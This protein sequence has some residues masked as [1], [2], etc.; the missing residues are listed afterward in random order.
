MAFQRAT[1]SRISARLSSSFSESSPRSPAHTCWKSV[2]GTVSIGLLGCDE[3][4]RVVVFG[5]RKPPRLSMSFPLLGDHC[6]G[7][8]CVSANLEVG[9]YCSSTISPLPLP[10]M[11]SSKAGLSGSG[12]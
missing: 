5:I 6:Y 12:I 1:R 10:S 2:A 11:K 7:K 9:T 4:D 8:H 3:L